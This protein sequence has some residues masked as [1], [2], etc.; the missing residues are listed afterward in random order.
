MEEFFESQQEPVAKFE[1]HKN[2]KILVI[3]ASD[4]KRIDLINAAKKLGITE[5]RLDLHLDYYDAK[6]FD[7]EK[8]HYNSNYAA[9]MLGPQPHSGISKGASGSI[10]AE[11]KKKDGYPPVIELQKNSSKH[12]LGIS[13]SNFSNELWKLI[14]K[15][16]IE[17]NRN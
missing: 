8:I 12:E 7:F 4:T 1:T 5:D 2:G 15:G 6:K 10:I 16:I 11:V 17:Q 14:R 9:I 13:K 3:G